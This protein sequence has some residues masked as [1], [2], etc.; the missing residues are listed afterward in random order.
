M[1]LIFS[2]SYARL[3]CSPFTTMASTL[4]FHASPHYK[5]SNSGFGV[6]LWFDKFF[7]HTTCSQSQFWLVNYCI[8]LK[9]K[10][11]ILTI[12]KAAEVK[13]FKTIK[14]FKTKDTLNLVWFW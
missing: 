11:E 8:F 10:Q 1:V 7:N 3:G 4:N 9:P 12:F 6:I 5:E 2:T 13:Y 14:H